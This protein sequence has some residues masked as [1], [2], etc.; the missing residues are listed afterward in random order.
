MKEKIIVN[1]Q[2]VDV[3]PVN[4]VVR[5]EHTL[6]SDGKKITHEV[7]QMKKRSIRYII[8]KKAEEKAEEKA[9]QVDLAYIEFFV[10]EFNKRYKTKLRIITE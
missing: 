3:K 1:S 6:K 4:G 5:L 2:I 9:K 10:E 8:D 7:K